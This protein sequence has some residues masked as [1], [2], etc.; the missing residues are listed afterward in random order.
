MDAAPLQILFASRLRRHL[1][2]TTHRYQ[3]YMALHFIID[4]HAELR[5]GD[6][7]H[8]LEGDWVW[9]G[10]PGPVISFAPSGDMPQLHYRAALRGDRLDAWLA[11]GLWPRW[12]LPVRDAPALQRLADRLL[13]QLSGDEAL[14]TRLR[15]NALEAF[16]L[17]LQRQQRAI[18]PPPSWVLDAQRRLE[19]EWNRPV[20]YVRL[21]ARYHMPVHALRRGF[22]QATGVPIHTW[23][24]QHRHREAQRLLLETDHPVAHIAERCGFADVAFFSRQFKRFAGLAPSAYR[25]AAYG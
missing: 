12:P 11:E 13:E 18:E 24:L 7:S 22:K 21:A 16:L 4:G 25:R 6:Q 17:E 8:H 5:I 3:T 1:G 20:D 9:T 2:T 10:F 14:D 23:L 15:A 19:R